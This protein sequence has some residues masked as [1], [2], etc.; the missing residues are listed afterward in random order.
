MRSPYV[1][2][3]DTPV[4]PSPTPTPA[5]R[6]DAG[7][8]PHLLAVLTADGREL[9][10]PVVSG[11][12]IVYGPI[13]GADDLPKGLVDDQ[14]PGRYRLVAGESGTYFDHVATANSWK[15][16]LFPPE[17]KI[18]D[19]AHADGALTVTAPP[20]D[21]PARAFIGVRACDLRAMGILGKV[22][23]NG[24][25]ADPAYA[26][27]RRNALIVAVNCGR[28]GGTCFCTSMGTGP[29]ADGG[30]DL[31]LTEVPAGGDGAPAYFTLVAGSDAGRRILDRLDLNRATAAEVETA[32][33][34][35]AA[36]ADSM[37]REMI[38]DAAEMLGDNLD[39][40]HWQTV[41]ERCLN[42]A[43]CTMACPTCFCS[44]VE[45]VTDL[46]GDNA[47]RWRKWDSCFTLDHSYMHGGSLRRSGAAR[48]RQWITHKLAHWHDQ[49]G[50]SGCTGCGRCITWCPVGIDI[51]EEARAVRDRAAGT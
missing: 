31:A 28:A 13:T 10:G 40:P 20:V 37:G 32:A 39:S 6:L 44:T 42:C 35:V 11:G 47:E 41:A 49:F 45:D 3:P 51:T 7:R 9:I 23:D 29:K 33:A 48:Y 30:Y 21:A 22:F 46:T 25:F 16:F 34:R 15:T 14:A 1:P 18:C 38:A 8:L 43:N 50:T 27:R 19:I 36:C 12:A 17:Q 5:L 24:D 4:V 26:A 2:P